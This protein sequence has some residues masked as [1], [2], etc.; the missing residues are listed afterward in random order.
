MAPKGGV[1]RTHARSSAPK[2]AFA[3]LHAGAL[4]AS[5]WFAFGATLPDAV[6]ARLLF[7]VAALYFLRH[8]ITLFVLLQRKVAYGEAV[9]LS[10]FLAALEIG[11]VVLGGRGQGGAV[12]PIGGLDALGLVMVIIG[13]VLNTGSELQR[14]Q[15]KQDPANRGHCYTGGMFAGSMHINY[16]G[17]TVMFA[18]W[19]LLTANL[20]TLAL[21]L[22]MAVSFV[23]YH[24]PGLDAYLLERYGDEFR[25]YAAR[26]AKFVPWLY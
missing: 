4:A 2:L 18:G 5:G 17:D 26:T 10:L 3:L 8:L 13:S 22:F 14:R 1:D 15:W 12:V 16:F 20:W 9:G 21:P 19:A 24:I 25:A 23:G 7:A 11:F 6:R